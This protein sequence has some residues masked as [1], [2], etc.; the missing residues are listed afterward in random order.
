MRMQRSF[1]DP[2]SYSRLQQAMKQ[3]AL[4]KYADR[5]ELK[6]RLSVRSKMI[7]RLTN[8]PIVILHTDGSR[9]YYNAMQ[10]TKR[11]NIGIST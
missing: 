7:A 9:S 5:N 2:E 6:Q 10:A 11:L 4:E 3:S 8:K 1:L